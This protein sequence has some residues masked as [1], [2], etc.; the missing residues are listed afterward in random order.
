MITKKRKK[1]NPKHK[2]CN[3]NKN[4]ICDFIEYNL[5]NNYKFNYNCN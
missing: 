3:E 4:Q 2:K 5:Y 1:R